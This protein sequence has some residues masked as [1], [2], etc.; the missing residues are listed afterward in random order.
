GTSV[1][2]QAR[3]A[4]NEAAFGAGLGTAWC[5][6]FS[7]PSPS[8]GVNTQPFAGCP[9]LDHHRWLQIDI[10]LATTANGVR[11]SVSDVKRSGVTEEQAGRAALLASPPRC[12]RS[13]GAG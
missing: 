13:P 8:S 6:P 2:I 9:F 11:P 7:A 5:G 4:D 10:K 12:L 1:T 3:A